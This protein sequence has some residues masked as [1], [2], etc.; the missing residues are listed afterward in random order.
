MLEKGCIFN[1]RITRTSS[2]GDFAFSKTNKLGSV[3]EGKLL[4][5]RAQNIAKLSRLT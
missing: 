2:C 4:K 5:R 1:E 3:R